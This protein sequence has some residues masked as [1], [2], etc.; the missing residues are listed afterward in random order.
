MLRYARIPGG[1]L[2]IV[3]T[4]SVWMAHASEVPA[5]K[6]AQVRIV[7]P[8]GMAGWVAD[9]KGQFSKEPGFKAPGRVNLATGQSYRLKL[10]GISDRPGLELYP[11]LELPK[12]D[13]RAAT[14]LSNSAIPIEFSEEDFDRAVTGKEVVTRVVY[15]ANPKCGPKD[16]D[17]SPVG[18]HAIVSY[19]LAGKD[20]LKEA[21]RRGTVLAVVH[22]GNID[23]AR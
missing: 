4:M 14:F 2:L 16:A 18:V 22:L 5:P 20:T 7:A 19:E 3:L 1:L 9:A 11:T 10:A 23:L 6:A 15:L 13:T 8:T 17:D 21:K 12:S